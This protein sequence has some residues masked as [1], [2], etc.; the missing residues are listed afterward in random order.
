MSAEKAR[1]PF[2]CCSP[3]LLY[4][5][6]P[7]RQPEIG[8]GVLFDFALVFDKPIIYTDTSFD[9][10]IYDAWWLDQP[11][12]TFEVLPKLGLRLTREDLPRVGEL[13]DL[14]LEDPRFQAAS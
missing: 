9:K 5:V 10:G 3:F 11:L 4:P 14:C 12:W 6:S 2:P 7:T 13:I 8:S 1:F